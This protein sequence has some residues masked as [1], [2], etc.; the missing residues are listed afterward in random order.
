MGIAYS[1]HPKHRRLKMVECITQHNSFNSVITLS[2]T[3]VIIV[4]GAIMLGAIMLG[5]IM[6]GAIMLS[7]MAPLICLTLGH[8]RIS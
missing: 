4:L 6:L 1:L 7:N 3:F 8:S 5:A 2:V